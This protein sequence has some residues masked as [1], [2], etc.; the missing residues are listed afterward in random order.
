MKKTI[1]TNWSLLLIITA[2]LYGL[3]IAR[4]PA[5]ISI[6]KQDAWISLLIAIIIGLLIIY[7]NTTLANLYPDKTFIEVIEHLL[8]KWLGSF[9]ILNFILLTIIAASQRA[10]F[11]ADFFTTSYLVR[12]SPYLVTILFI[13]AVALALLY[14]L[15]TFVRTIQ[16]FF[17]IILIMFMLSVVLSL[18][19]SKI[20][21]LFPILENGIIP[22]LKGTI[23]ILS[24][25]VFPIILI[26]IIYPT[27][28][29]YPKK[30]QKFVF[31]GYLF[32]MLF[33]FLS[34]FMSILVLGSNFI[35]FD[36]R[37]TFRLIQEINIGIIFSRT[38]AL[39]VFIWLTSIYISTFV[40][41]YAGAIGIS[42]LLRL[43]DYKKIVL[44]LG[45]I[46][47][48]LSGYI[49]Y[50]VPYEIEWSNYVWPPYIFTFGFI[51]PVILLVIALIRKRNVIE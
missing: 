4:I 2:F 34:I 7:I 11:I 47:I 22:P 51:L 32:S 50:N 24:S 5:I 8:G 26:H 49:Y 17:Y 20:D 16:I 27:N 31:L 37:P 38:E 41:Y 9:V 44:P 12:T 33:V 45:L 21:N 46:I 18:P 3:V 42:Q 29:K 10:W 40:Y 39:S 23:H 19:E 1:I 15:E 48:V 28:L 6:A 14:G 43:K 13:T 36:R 25:T 30:S 35:A